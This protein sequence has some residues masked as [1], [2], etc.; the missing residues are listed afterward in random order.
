MV[1]QNAHLPKTVN[2]FNIMILGFGYMF[3]PIFNHL[4]FLIE[5]QS[6]N[7]LL[8]FFDISKPT[9]RRCNYR[10][11]DSRKCPTSIPNKKHTAPLRQKCFAFLINDPPQFWKVLRTPLANPKGSQQISASIYWKSKHGHLS[12]NVFAN[13]GPWFEYFREHFSQVIKQ[14]VDKLLTNKYDTWRKPSSLTR[15]QLWDRPVTRRDAV[16]G[17]TIALNRNA[18]KLWTP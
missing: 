10:N 18:Q 7:K 6:S 13:S 5:F 2:V 15:A 9:N 3:N 12:A 11:S 8:I 17:Y 1:L 16:T 14:N 4:K